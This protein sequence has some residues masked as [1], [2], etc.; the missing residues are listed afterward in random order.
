MSVKIYPSMLEGEPLETH[1]IS[2]EIS[3]INFISSMAKKDVSSQEAHPIVVYLNGTIQ[4]DLTVKITNSD[5]V[6]IYPAPR[7]DWTYAVY[8]VVVMV[9]SYFVTKSMMRDAPK[10]PQRGKELGEAGAEANIAKLLQPVPQILGKDKTFPSYLVNPIT[11]FV[12]KRRL[13]VQTALCVGI[14]EYSIDE[15]LLKIG[16]TPFASFD[17]DVDYA[18]YAPGDD[19]S[20]D[21]RFDNWYVCN[22]VGSTNSGSAGLDTAT[23][24]ESDEPIVA[25]YTA[26]SGFN[27]TIGGESPSW[28]SFATGTDLFIK[29]PNNYTVSTPASYNRITGDFSELEPFNGMLV[30][31][32]TDTTNYSLVVVAYSP[33]VAAVAGTGG[34]A[35]Y[36]TAS[37]APSTFDFITT[38]ETW[39]VTFNGSTYTIF[40]G[41][42]YE[43][44]TVLVADITSQLHGSGLI[45]VDLSG[46]IKIVEAASPYTGLA[47]TQS[48]DPARIFGASPAYNTGTAS[49]GGTA[50]Q[51]AYIEL[52]DDF[53]TP[54]ASLSNGA[55]RLAI[56]YR[57][58]TY[59]IVSGSGLTI[60]LERLDDTGVVDATWGGFNTRM[61][62]DFSITY[63]DATV[64]EWLGPF[65]AC[66]ENEASDTLEVD[67]F[68]PQGLC[69][70][71]KDGTRKQLTRSAIVEWRDADVAGSWTSTQY[72]YTDATEDA[73]GFTESIALG[74]SIA[75]PEVRLRRAF[76]ET[77]S[78]VRDKIIWY[79][80]RSKLTER[81]DSYPDITSIGVTINNS[82][83][84]SALSNRKINLVA[85][86]TY[87]GGNTRSIKDAVLT[88][89]DSLGIDSALVD[90]VTLDDLQDTYWTPRGE[91]FDAAIES[92]TTAR[93]MLQTILSA[94]TSHINLSHGLISAIREGIQ[95]PVGMLTPHDMT[96][97]L[98]IGFIAPSADDFDGVD[99]EYRSEDTWKNETVQCRL[100][101]SPGL[102]VEKIKLIGVT[103][104]TRAWRIGMRRLHKIAGQRLSFSCGTE[105]DALCYE[106]LDHIVLSDDVQ[107]G[108]HRSVIIESMEIDGADAILT[109]SESLDW[110]FTAPRVIIRRHDGTVTGIETP[111]EIDDYTLSVPLAFIDFDLITDLSIEP[112]RLIF[113]ESTTVGYKAL[114][115][116]IEPS[117]NGTCSLTAIEYNDDYYQDD[118]N[119]AP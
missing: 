5:D 91:T 110:T 78:N 37:A 88:L 40:L 82:D 86:R 17:T 27:L 24:N 73:I 59:R 104:K 103:N 44:I 83:K 4:E 23:T 106:Y 70:Y 112:A 81:P 50:E 48:A 76:H 39:D 46:K 3:L 35:S 62:Y 119:E 101:G 80:L 97:E 19:V 32:S 2:K 113:A 26:L 56:S 34:S 51:L 69:W 111:V 31:L 14:G 29:L 16:D 64:V 89:T 55:I 85:D 77:G 118:D 67:I 66:P 57:D 41:A 25:D 9:V 84:I 61:V 105:M 36:I 30:T 22:E 42:D 21:S 38:S 18:I 45:A 90:T 33:Y 109:V 47:I 49:T 79:G 95:E 116:S 58:Y 7:L 108:G 94:G 102:K 15:D 11:R 53:S 43:T 65:V 93:D 13:Q 75:R 60:E 68:F 96:E 28:P 87:A 71:K 12:D 72:D 10:I 117:N 115:Q 74:S 54:F 99:V 6:K 100:D 92:S 63:D 107:E 20:A 114:I 8:M 52:D 98:K 1:V